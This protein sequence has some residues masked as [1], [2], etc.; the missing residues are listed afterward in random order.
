MRCSL[1]EMDGDTGHRRATSSSWCAQQSCNACPQD[2]GPPRP[3]CVWEVGEGEREI[4]GERLYWARGQRG[5][6]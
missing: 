1:S 3:P 5:E 2:A 4:E 6:R